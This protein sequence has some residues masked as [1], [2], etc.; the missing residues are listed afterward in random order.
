MPLQVHTH[1]DRRFLII[2]TIVVVGG[3]R[4]S[5]ALLQ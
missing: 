3:K 1:P 5:A 2:A 4:C